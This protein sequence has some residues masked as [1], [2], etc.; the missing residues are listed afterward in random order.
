M[1]VSPVFAKKRQ[2]EAA[3]DQVSDPV[4]DD[5]TCSRRGYNTSDVDMIGGRGQESSSNKDCLSGKG[6][7]ALSSATTTEMIQGPWTWTKPIR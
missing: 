3:P 7:P 4:S 5:R 1:N 6:T 2:S